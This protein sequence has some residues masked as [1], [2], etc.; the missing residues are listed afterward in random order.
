MLAIPENVL[1]RFNE[2][3]RQRAIQEAFHVHY[4]RW[5]RY[6]L[7]F[8][9]KYPPPETKSE[10]VRLFIEKLKSKKQTPQQCAQA[11]HAISLLFLFRHV[12][13]KDFGDLRDVPRAK[14]SKYIP[15]VLSRP[16]VDAIIR[17]YPTAAKD[18]IWQWFLP[19]KELTPIPGT[20]ECRRY[21]LHESQ[22]QDALKRAARMAKLTK[23][24]K[25]HTFRHS[26]A[27]HFSQANYD[28]R[29]IQTMLG[30]TDVRTTMIYAHC[31]PSKTAKEAKSPL[32]F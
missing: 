7:D 19:Q 5:L 32:D 1:A 24:V 18:F 4:R 11:A 28:I 15:V 27:A 31:I 20:K 12:I 23:R 13:K 10:Q 30:H 29:T 3:L 26:S 17:Q 14:K 9:Q 21:H 8:C 6:F 25:S 22:V 16:E 2:V